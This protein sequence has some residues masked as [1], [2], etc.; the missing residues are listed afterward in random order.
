[1][2]QKPKG[3]MDLYGKKG[4]IY[5]YINNYISSFMSTYNYEYIKVPTFESSELYKRGVGNTTDIVNK[6]TYDFVDKGSRNMTLRPEFTA[7]IVRSL[8]ENKL[9]VNSEVNKF[10]YF[11]SCFRY[12]R[13]QSGRFREF[14]QFG[15]EV[16]GTSNPYMDVEVIII[17]YKFLSS[18][19]LKNLRVKINSL[20]DSESRQKY[21]E[22][23]INYF[24]DKTND[25]CETCLERLNT[26]P[27]RILDC[28][29]DNDKDAIKNAPKTI[30]YL[31]DE[32]KEFFDKVKK[33]LENN[34]IPFEVDTSLVRGL[35]YYTHTV[36]EIV[37]DNENLGKANTLCGGG[38]YDDLVETLGGPSIAG[39]GFSIGIERVIEIMEEEEV[40]VPE[41]N[42][43]VYL[44]NLVEDDDV[45]SLLTE[46]RENGYKTEID[47][48]SKSMKSQ[49]KLVDKYNPNFVL[50][51][52]EDELKGG[53]ITVRDNLTKENTQVKRDEVLN[54]L[55]MNF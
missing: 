13:P 17:A 19:G 31:N 20:G 11:G 46:L 3:T 9:Y 44:M 1:M 41:D 12:E 30:D 40:Y 47:Y 29:I 2:I 35:D 14:T 5:N 27:L 25:L 26:N 42:V 49:W 43:D 53:Y 45:Y 24:K 50:I 8:I 54:Y 39:I 23:L 37:S 28:K 10:Y 21:R 7:G 32:S 22:E 18:L 33:Q 51:Y 6:E 38:R 15:V 52:G 4:Y 48:T 16:F 34:D 55:S 36:F